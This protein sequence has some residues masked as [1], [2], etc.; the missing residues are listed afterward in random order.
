MIDKAQ[1]YF[2][3]AN[4]PMYAAGAE[5]ALKAPCVAILE[6]IAKGELKAVTDAEVVQ[7]I[8]H[9]YTALGRR[10]HAVEVCRLFLQVV[11]NVLPITR[12][13][14][15][16]ALE[17]HLQF[18]QLQARDSLHVAAMVEYKIARIISADR[19][20]DGVPGIF[21]LDPTQF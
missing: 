17:F 15:E 11:P 14:I 7:E 9:R 3:D 5:H 21:R 19:H 10:N 13:I 4:I 18:S 6:S 12:Q 1:V 8:L 20:F 16:R 2:I